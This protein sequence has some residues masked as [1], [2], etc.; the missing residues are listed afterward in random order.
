M[1]I[2]RNEIL[3]NICYTEL[4]YGRINKKLNIDFSKKQIEEFM[5]KVLKETEDDLISKIGKNYYV[6]NIENNIKITINANTYRVI[7]VDKIKR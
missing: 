6:T 5:L 3:K 4:V 2:I 1:I 7:T